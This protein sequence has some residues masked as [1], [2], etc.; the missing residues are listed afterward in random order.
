MQ[1]L[2]SVLRPDLHV[3]GL[4]S[5]EVCLVFRVLISS[6][7]NKSVMPLVLELGSSCRLLIN[8]L[9]SMTSNFAVYFTFFSLDLKVLKVF[10]MKPHP[11]FPRN[12]VYFSLTD[13][14]FIL[15]VAL[16]PGNQHLIAANYLKHKGSWHCLRV[17]M[18]CY[19]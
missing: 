1:C 18:R 11:F 10:S 13:T 8:Y 5:L 19:G 3:L 16:S 15:F 6:P 2:G 14:F 7:L 12:Y 9:S 4:R 17:A